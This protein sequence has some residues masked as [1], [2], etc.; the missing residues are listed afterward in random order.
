VLVLGCTADSSV[1][2]V[3][4]FLFL[5]EAHIQGQQVN[6]VELFQVD[7]SIGF[8]YICLS[9]GNTEKIRS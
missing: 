7:T 8:T 5:L 3:L 2:S 9:S 4:V 6:Q 1:D